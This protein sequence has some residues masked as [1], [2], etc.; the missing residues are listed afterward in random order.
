MV[1]E[2][3]CEFC[4]GEG[5]VYARRSSSHY[6]KEV[7]RKWSEEAHSLRGPVVSTVLGHFSRECGA[8]CLDF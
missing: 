5:T 3:A 8:D 4:L 1:E 2:A 7:I 6:F